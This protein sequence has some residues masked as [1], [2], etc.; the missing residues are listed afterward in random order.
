MGL[1]GKQQK[2]KYSAEVSA[3]KKKK[4]HL[5][6]FEQTPDFNFEKVKFCNSHTQ[7]EKAVHM[8][9]V[10][11]DRKEGGCKRLGKK[12]RKQIGR[13]EGDSQYYLV[14]KKRSKVHCSTRDYTC[15]IFATPTMVITEYK[16]R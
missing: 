5:P 6:S 8:I 1:W 3:F 14:Q 16:I 12:R 13:K 2:E 10:G 15:H 9:V 7:R 4:K 11:K